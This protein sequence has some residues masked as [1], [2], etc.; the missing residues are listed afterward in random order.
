MRFVMPLTDIPPV[1]MAVK[2]GI[3]GCQN[4]FEISRGIPPARAGPLLHVSLPTAAAINSIS[5]SY[6]HR[7]RTTSW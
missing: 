6:L 5:R 7:I 1:P 4:Y 3:F 2:C